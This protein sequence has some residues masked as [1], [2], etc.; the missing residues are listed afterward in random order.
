VEFLMNGVGVSA[1]HIA[2]NESQRSDGGYCRSLTALVTSWPRGEHQL[3]IRVT[4]T[5]PTDDGWNLY[6]AGTH[7][8]KYFVNVGN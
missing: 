1:D 3:E 7:T 8:F 5:Q 4:F 6:P 2:I